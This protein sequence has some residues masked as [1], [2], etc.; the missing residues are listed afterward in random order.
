[1]KQSVAFLLILTLFLCWSKVAKPF[2]PLKGCA[3]FAD[4][5]QYHRLASKLKKLKTKVKV[6]QTMSS[7]PKVLNTE[8]ADA[9]AQP[10]MK[11]ASYH[12]ASQALHAFVKMDI[13][14]IIGDSCMSV[15]QIADTIQSQFGGVSLQRRMQVNQDGLLRIM[16][17]LVTVGILYEEHNTGSDLN[18]EPSFRL[19]STGALL[20]TNVPGQQSLAPIILHWMEKPLWN[21]WS[22]LP[23]YV[24][25]IASGTQQEDASKL[26]FERAN[27]VI[28]DEYY[29][30]DN[31]ESLKHAN[32]FVRYISKGEEQAVLTGY[33]WASLSGRIVLDVGGYQGK[34]MAVIAKKYPDVKCICFDLPEVVSTTSAPEG[35]E[36]I[37]G[38][39]FDGSLPP[40]DII[41]M[42]HFLDK[43]MWSEEQAVQILR[44]CRDA[45]PDDGNVI[46]AEAVL[47][48][49][50]S[51]ASG[52]NQLHLF[53]DVLFLLVGRDAART[54]SE[55]KVLAEKAG[56]KVHRI[57]ATAT[58]SCYM[59]VLS[60]QHT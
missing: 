22:E 28:S 9:S 32:E 1:M 24:A 26:P 45:L 39:I 23:D 36:V 14:N 18:Q 30:T 6:L 49:H 33:D 12:F 48:D 13:P 27:G 37:G 29:C 2:A 50:A 31:A 19:T 10:L 56:L 15:G 21:A 55:W 54:E 41:F 60:K 3:V 8:D 38:D 46:I 25:G 47:P 7:K 42:K 53:I 52:T 44:L 57:T 51:N 40:C 20:Q 16:R 35:V 11:L 58:P 34:M 4:S 43:C 5:R 17:L 59:I